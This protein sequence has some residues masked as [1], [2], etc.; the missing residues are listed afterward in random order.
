VFYRVCSITSKYIKG[1]GLPYARVCMHLG[2]IAPRAPLARAIVRD[3]I[4]L[5]PRVA[6]TSWIFSYS[7]QPAACPDATNSTDTAVD[8]TNACEY[9]CIYIYIYIY[10]HVHINVHATP[11]TRARDCARVCAPYKRQLN[12]WALHP[13]PHSCLPSVLLSLSLSLSSLPRHPSTRCISAL[14]YSLPRR[15]PVCAIIITRIPIVNYRSM[16]AF[17]KITLSD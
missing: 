15:M 3:A 8:P 6:L 10:I 1:D 2:C 7:F 4:D 9:I 16:R 11:N 13:S 17:R 12:S 5:S 14:L